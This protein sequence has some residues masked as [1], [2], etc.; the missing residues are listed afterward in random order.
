[1][2]CSNPLDDLYELQAPYFDASFSMI[3][4]LDLMA[5]PFI[6]EAICVATKVRWMSSLIKRQPRA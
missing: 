1:M 6:H 5:L 3:S 4:G 2:H